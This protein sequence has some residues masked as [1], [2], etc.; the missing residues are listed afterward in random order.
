MKFLILMLS[1]LLQRQ[2]SRS[3][4]RR[5]RLWF[6][7]LLQPFAL[8]QQNMPLQVL[9]YFLAV[10]VPCIVL[11]VLLN[12]MDGL[13]LGALAVLLQV[14][15]FLYVLGRDDFNARLSCYREAWQ[16][17]DYQA[18]FECARSF[19]SLQA[20]TSVIKAESLHFAVSDALNYAWFIRFFV[21]VFWFMSFGLPGAFLWL[22]SFWFMLELKRE[23]SD[24]LIN[25]LLW[26]PARL[27]ALTFCLAGDFVAG[28]KEVMKSL[29]NPELA[30]D[31]L[32][33]DAAR[34]A[35][36]KQNTQDF[37]V[38]QAVQQLDEQ[39]G[40]LLRAAIIWLVIIAAATI[41]GH[42]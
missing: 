11:A 6:A 17:Q 31:V 23:W 30:A 27:L 12:H 25:A 18:A 34:T 2:T 10:V 21:P 3:G 38:Q 33:A 5:K 26:I 35:L 1:L 16:R 28:F 7:R 41:S 13:L 29:R 32:L 22:F 24:N 36:G 19:L 9:V 39:H 20:Q 4:Y 15:L 40:L 8:Q 37:D 42:L 14:G